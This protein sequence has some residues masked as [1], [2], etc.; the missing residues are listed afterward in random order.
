MGSDRFD[1]NISIKMES[2]IANLIYLVTNSVGDLVHL[3]G[4]IH[5]YFICLCSHMC[6]CSKKKLLWIYLTNNRELNR[7]QECSMIDLFLT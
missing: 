5:I 1:K 3:V 4:D 7:N 2:F 6:R